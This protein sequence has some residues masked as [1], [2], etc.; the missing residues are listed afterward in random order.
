MNSL[1]V[2][3]QMKSKAPLSPLET[4]GMTDDYND[5]VGALPN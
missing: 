3:E 4:S 1:R 5:E 2:I